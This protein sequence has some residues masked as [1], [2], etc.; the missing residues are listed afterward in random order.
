MAYKPWYVRAAEIDSADERDEFIRG[1]FGPAKSS[2]AA[3]A[4]TL[5]SFVAGWGLGSSIAKKRKK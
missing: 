2:P 1:V 3:A 4:L 5:A